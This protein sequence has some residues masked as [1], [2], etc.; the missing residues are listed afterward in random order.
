MLKRKINQ[1][2]TGTVG[3]KNGISRDDWIKNKLS[4]LQKGSLILDAG[5]GEGKYKNQNI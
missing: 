3:T 4:N 1:V 2:I 5:A